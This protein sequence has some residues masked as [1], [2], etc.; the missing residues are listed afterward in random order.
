MNILLICFL[1]LCFDFMYLHV[2][3]TVYIWRAYFQKGLDPLSVK[4]ELL[5]SW[6]YSAYVLPLESI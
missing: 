4:I 1:T 6:H 2:M 5:I 3:Y